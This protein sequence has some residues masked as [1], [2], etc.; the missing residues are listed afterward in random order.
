MPVMALRQPAWFRTLVLAQLLVALAVAGGLWLLRSQALDAETAKLG[1]LARAM[2]LQADRS[3][4]LGVTV[5]RTTQAELAHGLIA[6]RG[7]ATDALLRERVRTLGGYRA[8]SVF[9]AQGRRLATSRQD[10]RTP[11]AS[12]AGL[13]FFLA[14]QRAQAPTLLLSAPYRAPSDDRLSVSLSMGWY[15]PDGGFQGV[16][17]LVADPDRKSTRLNSSHSQQSRMPSSA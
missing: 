4:G 11:A 7:A 5:L 2:A 6:P 8:L 13:D 1:A 12:V 17:A 9:D 15:G 3:L 16:L 14:A 10:E